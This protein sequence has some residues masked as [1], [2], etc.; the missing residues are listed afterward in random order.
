M[1]YSVSRE[2]IIAGSSVNILKNIVSFN[3]W[4]SWSPWACL[5]PDT[6]SDCR[7][8]YMSWESKLTGAGNMQRIAHNDTSV[9]IA[10]EFIKPFKSKANVTFNV[11]NVAENS[12]KI[13]WTMESKL[14]LFLI[15]FKKLFQAM[16]GRDFE[17]G[18]TR[19][20]YLVETGQVPCQIEYI[21]TPQSVDTFTMAGVDADC[22]LANIG[23]S[24]H[25]SFDNLR[26]LTAKTS[27][28]PLKMICQY[29]KMSLIKSS[30]DYTAAAVYTGDIT[31]PNGLTLKTI[32]AHKAIKVILRGNYDFMG[33][34]WSGIYCHLRGLKLKANK[35]VAPYDVYIK[36]PMDTVNP[37]EY[38]TE[39]YLPV[40]NSKFLT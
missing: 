23:N 39:V 32:P 11:E 22:T 40:K 25:Q 9:N 14:P 8:D 37:N 5:D 20:K 10:L 27:I 15:F 31:N 34:A 21:D 13:T 7:D 18:L 36:G 19:L 3:H 1:K 38:V 16:I 26:D 2:K 35:K 12:S 6:K 30:F 17:R 29:N 28:I 4:S 33:D 24:M